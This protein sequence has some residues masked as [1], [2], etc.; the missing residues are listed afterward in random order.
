LQ[1]LREL[2][3]LHEAWAN[4]KLTPYHAYGF[5]LYRNQ[6]NLLMHVDKMDTHVISCILHIDSSDDAE[7]WPILIEDFQ[8]NTNEVVLKSGQML[9]YE[10]SKCFHGR[11]KKFSGS[12]YSSIFVHYTPTDG[13]KDIDHKMEAHY[14]VPPVWNTPPTLEPPLDELQMVGTSM[15]EPDCPD[16]WCALPD[17]VKWPDIEGTYGQVLTTGHK[18]FPL[19]IETHEEL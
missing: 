18:H 19:N 2:K 1:V 12:W 9:F 7:P 4:T 10:S 8:G 15:K 11:P 13:W 3:P 17:T 5:R 6:S 16:E 14:A